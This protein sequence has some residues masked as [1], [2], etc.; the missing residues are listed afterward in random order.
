MALYAKVMIC[1]HDFRCRFCRK[2]STMRKLS[3][4]FFNHL[5]LM[6]DLGLTR[7]VE[8]NEHSG[9]GVRHDVRDEFDGQVFGVLRVFDSIF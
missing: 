1:F 5:S 7:R 2:S 3:S 8:G 9:G 4:F 6:R